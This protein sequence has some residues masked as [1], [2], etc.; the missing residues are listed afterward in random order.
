M[1]ILSDLA[2]APGP[3]HALISLAEKGVPHG[4]VQIDLRYGV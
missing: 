4:T 3:R 1:I 2:T